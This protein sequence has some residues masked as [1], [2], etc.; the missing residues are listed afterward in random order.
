MVTV[1]FERECQRYRKHLASTFEVYLPTPDVRP[2]RIH[3]AMRYAIFNGGKRLR[4]ILV[5]MTGE[6]LGVQ[7]SAL[8]PPALAVE[9]I[10]TYSLVHDDLPSMDDDDMRRDLP[11]CHVRFDEATAILVGDALQALAYQVISHDTGNCLRSDQRTKMVCTLAEAA[12]STGLVGGQVMDLELQNNSDADIELDVMHSM[13]T[14]ALINCAVQ[15][16]AIAANDVTDN[17]FEKLTVYGQSLGLAFQCVDDILDCENPEQSSHS[18]ALALRDR[19]VE[20][21]Q[22]LNFNTDNL[23]NM[24]NFFVERNY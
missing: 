8:A 4:A 12:G 11:S 20:A 21:L 19:A 13:K 23:Q 5:Y 1:S 2:T 3:E 24:A 15:L 18:K 7:L 9:L 6:M 16:G 17:D 14:G 10:H 22:D